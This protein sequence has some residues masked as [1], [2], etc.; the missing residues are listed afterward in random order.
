[1]SMSWKTKESLQFTNL[2]PTFSC[3]RNYFLLLFKDSQNGSREKH[4]E[5]WCTYK[6]GSFKGHPDRFVADF[7]A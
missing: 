3:V 2:T 7:A 5:I 1:M 4:L 6:L